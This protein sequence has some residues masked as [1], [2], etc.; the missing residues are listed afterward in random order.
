MPSPT[1]TGRPRTTTGA[2]AADIPVGDRTAGQ[3]WR[4]LLAL[5]TPLVE[6]D[7]RC[8]R[9]VYDE[10]MSRLAPVVSA[11]QVAHRAEIGR[12]QQHWADVEDRARALGWDPETRTVRTPS[13]R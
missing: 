7:W 4:R 6:A 8:R 1:T 12:M 11:F 5:E 10:G 2:P 13:G 9:D 3:P